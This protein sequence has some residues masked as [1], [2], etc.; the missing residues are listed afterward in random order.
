[1]PCT[2]QVKLSIVKYER[3][4]YLDCLDNDD[5]AE[6]PLRKEVFACPVETVDSESYIDGKTMFS[7][8][9]IG[10]ID[11]CQLRMPLCE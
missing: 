8:V 5:V 11:Y 4:I 3:D 9:V 1:M 10:R 6:F 2:T 7:R